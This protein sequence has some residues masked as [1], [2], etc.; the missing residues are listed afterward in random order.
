[1]SNILSES[2]A[3][4]IKSKIISGHYAIGERIPNE[5]QIAEILK[6]S[7]N[8]VREAIKILIS[9][10]I[11]EIKRGNG[12][13]V[14]ENPGVSNDP[15]GVE[16]MNQGNLFGYLI[17][18][19][20]IIEPEI[21]AL[22]AQRAGEEEISE[23]L[24]VV[25]KLHQEVDKFETLGV[26]NATIEAVLHLDM[27]FHHTIAKICHNPVLERLEPVIHTHL[28]E[29]YYMEKV[30]D[31]QKNFVGNRKHFEIYSAIKERDSERVRKLCL[32]HIDG[33]SNLISK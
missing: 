21:A 23:L 16:F 20:R 25:N 17:E 5:N 13:Y 30:R 9:K 24:N 10:N 6:V 27:E 7:R 4:Q 11:L 8:T 15:F 31:I 3:N 26:N 14:C 2:V 32:E 1:M 18:T 22:A 33:A 19:R 12:T 29:L 28:F